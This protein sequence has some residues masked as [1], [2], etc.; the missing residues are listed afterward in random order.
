MNARHFPFQ[1]STLPKQAADQVVTEIAGYKLAFEEYK[2]AVKG[3][4]QPKLLTESKWDKYTPDQMFWISY[5][6]NTCKRSPHFEP[7]APVATVTG[8]LRNSP[9]FAKDFNCKDQS[10]MN[11]GFKCAFWS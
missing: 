5:A 1:E 6:T 4:K 7:P 3:I 8:G 11:K 2:D 10:N 9:E